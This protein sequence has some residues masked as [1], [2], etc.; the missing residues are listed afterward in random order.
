MYVYTIGKTLCVEKKTQSKLMFFSYTCNNIC[1][2]NN[3]GK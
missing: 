1:S 2:V 3:K